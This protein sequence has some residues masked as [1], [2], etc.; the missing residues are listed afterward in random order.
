MLVSI[1]LALPSR[2]VRAQGAGVRA[3]DLEILNFMRH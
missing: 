1:E 2:D 3:V